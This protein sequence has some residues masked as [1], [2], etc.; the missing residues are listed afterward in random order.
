MYTILIIK[1]HD[2]ILL[3][4]RKSVT[5]GNGLY[6]LPGG[7]IEEGESARS[8]AI[9]EAA[10][11]LAITIKP[12]DLD[13][14]HVLHRKGELSE[15]FAVCFQVRNWSGPIKNNEPD[16][17]EYL[18]WLTFDEIEHHQNM[19]PAHKQVLLNLKRNIIYSE[20]GW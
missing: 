7:K 9:R 12:D 3:Q 16:K 14:V 20:H 19:V 18:T 2:K 8:A 1:E 15:F 4:K 5:F 10:E 11:E 6:A 17:C 13:F